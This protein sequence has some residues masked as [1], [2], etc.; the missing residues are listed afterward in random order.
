MLSVCKRASWEYIITLMSI[1]LT[2]LISN[3]IFGSLATRPLTLAVAMVSVF[4]VMEDLTALTKYNIFPCSSSACIVSYSLLFCY[5]SIIL[6]SSTTSSIVDIFITAKLND[7][8][9][10][11]WEK[12]YFT[13][14]L[15]KDWP[16]RAATTGLLTKKN[17]TPKGVL[18]MQTYCRIVVVTLAYLLAL[19]CI[20][21]YVVLLITSHRLGTVKYARIM[22]RPEM[23]SKIQLTDFISI[24]LNLTKIAL[25]Q[26]LS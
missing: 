4:E 22:F 20:I 25:L 7:T 13:G 6:T 24:V 8:T 26:P 23:V 10:P 19:I 9:W 11:S 5:W 2:Y 1:S 15:M 21:N 3:W 16:K 12:M 18:P 17:M 14:R